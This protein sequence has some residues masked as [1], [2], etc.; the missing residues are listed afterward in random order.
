MKKI[1]YDIPLFPTQYAQLLTNFLQSNPQKPD[2]NQQIS[3][4]EKSLAALE[5]DFMT[6]QE[7]LRILGTLPSITEDETLPFQFGKALNFTEHGLLGYVWLAK[8]DPM[9]L[10]DALVQHMS[11]KLPFFQLTTDRETFCI[12]IQLHDLWELGEAR[13]FLA[14]IYFGSIYAL[15]EKICGNVEIECDFSG[16]GPASLTADGTPTHA[17]VTWKFDC[18]CNR[19]TLQQVKFMEPAEKQQFMQSMLSPDHTVPSEP[20]S[21]FDNGN[22]QHNSLE[23]IVAS[24]V[25]K[26]FKDAN[27]E[28]IALQLGIGS[29]HLRKQLA[30][31]G[32][33]FKEIK[34][35]IRKKFALLYVTETGISLHD[36]AQML[37]FG[38]QASF[39][40]AYRS[41]TGTTPG[42]AR[43][44][45]TKQPDIQ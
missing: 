3:I 31:E 43:R 36:I 35:E 15:A 17:H 16:H 37:G 8:I 10:V 32:T 41:W 38:D 6:L 33:S 26:S 12:H 39:T 11:I 44:L 21:H 30:A 9:Q 24:L 7:I 27:I 13:A 40:R 29:R 23:A 14:R 2:I 42:D 19:I 22:Q 18:E 25:K 34:S 1:D 4:L 28:S 5:S 45:A 20:D